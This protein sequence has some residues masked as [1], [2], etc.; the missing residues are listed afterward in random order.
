MCD[1]VFDA[2]RDAVIQRA[3]AA[4]IGAIVTVGET[5]ADAEKNLALADRYPVLRPAAGLFPTHLDPDAAA[6]P[7]RPPAALN[8]GAHPCECRAQC[9][10]TVQ[11]GK[12]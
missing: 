3:I 12:K 7:M 9:K 6:A 8:A 2:D 10:K 1:A 5:L 11:I 4:G